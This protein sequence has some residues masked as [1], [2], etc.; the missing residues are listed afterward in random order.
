MKHGLVFGL[1]VLCFACS[2]SNA[3]EDV[4]LFTDLRA[5]LLTGDDVRHPN[6]LSEDGL[7]A[8]LPDTGT[9][10]VDGEDVFVDTRTELDVMEVTLAPPMPVAKCGMP[11]YDLINPETLGVPLDWQPIAFWKLP[12]DVLDTLL[13]IAG[14]TAL[15]PLPYGV[16]L[17]RFRYTTQDRGREVEATAILSLPTWLEGHTPEPFPMVLNTHGTTGFSD[18]CAPSHPSRE[19]EDPAIPAAMAA[20]GSVAVA[21][22]YIGLCGFGEPCDVRHA[23]LVGEQVAI[24]SWDAVRAARRLLPD[25]GF[26]GQVTDEVIPWGASQGGHAALFVEHYAPYYAP[27]FRVPG[28]LAMVPP[29]DLIPLLAEF[30]DAIGSGTG[31]LAVSFPAMHLW[32][33]EQ[34]DLADIFTNEEPLFIA[35][36]ITQAIFPTEKCGIDLPLSPSSATIDML[37]ID[38]F[39]A[40]VRE[41]QFPQFHPWYCFYLENSLATS[42]VPPLR[43]TPTLMV[44]GEQDNLV[45]T[46]LMRPDFVR[47]C[48]QGFVLQYL[49]CLGGGHVEGSLWSLPEQWRW[50]QHRR[51]GIPLDPQQVCTIKPPECCSG[52]PS[53]VCTL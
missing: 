10:R 12:A 52:A 45:L 19:T 5:D 17:F 31:L 7:S 51:K 35:D 37:F 43:H 1:L 20:L 18:P 11:P 23:Y 44:Y 50:I 27:E 6:D 30:S 24:A 13:A 8:D 25:L 41:G 47:L 34:G 32:Y 3:R 38:S 2:S 46:D 14:Y 40:L 26:T 39:R 42:S 28:V 9:D 21:P 22:D 49:E 15:S 29:S 36:T 53:S 48:Q 16:S 33:G 4:E